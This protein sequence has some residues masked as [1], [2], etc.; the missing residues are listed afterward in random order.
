MTT[1]AVR[2]TV[3]ATGSEKVFSGDS[4]LSRAIF[5][6]SMAPYITVLAQYEDSVESPI[7]HEEYLTSTPDGVLTFARRPKQSSA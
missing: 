4:A 6:I 1:Y 7:A 5:L 2:Y 3:N